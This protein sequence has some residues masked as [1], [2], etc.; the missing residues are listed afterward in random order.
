MRGE[1]LHYDSEH[2]FGFITG[3]DGKRYVFGREDLRRDMALSKGVEVEFQPNGDRA[4][5]IFSVRTRAADPANNVAATAARPLPGAA[6]AHFG[7]DAENETESTAVWSYFWRD[8]TS[9]YLNFTGRARRKE[10]WS[11]CLFWP[12]GLA[13]L[14]AIGLSYDLPTDDFE[15][16]SG[17]P[18]LTLSLLGLYAVFTILPWI[19]LLVRRL[20][21]VGLTGWLAILCFLPYVGELAILVFG[22][23]PSQSGQ[24]K[25]GPVPAGVRI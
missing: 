12:I 1:I 25:Y 14:A 16:G 13:V 21:D 7:R 2:G 5:N 11:F 8:L 10:F 4:G 18:I 6:S 24:N 19:S 17:L 9:N 23:I 20:H 22:L 15:G 3:A